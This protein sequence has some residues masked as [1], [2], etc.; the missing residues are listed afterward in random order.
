M[1]CPVL[2]YRVLCIVRTGRRK[3]TINPKQRRDEESVEVN[4]YQ[5]NT[6]S[7]PI[8]RT[9]RGVKIVFIW[10]HF[11]PSATNYTHVFWAAK[12]CPISYELLL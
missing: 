4:R 2:D 7:Q 9:A 11:T 5:K 6:Y 3:A 10:C 1:Q 8:M 12:D